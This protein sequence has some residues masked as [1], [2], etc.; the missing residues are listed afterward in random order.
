[1]R[2][3]QV[4][5]CR[6]LAE[7]FSKLPPFY[8]METC[9]G[10]DNRIELHIMR[11][12]P[13]NVEGV[14]WGTVREIESEAGVPYQVAIEW[15]QPAPQHTIVPA[16]PPDLTDEIEFPTDRLR[17]TWGKIGLELERRRRT[18]PLPPWPADRC[19]IC[20][21]PLAATV[22]EGCVLSNCSQRP[23]PDRRADHGF[24]PETG[25]EDITVNGINS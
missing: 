6:A 17:D 15:H 4:L 21:W 7:V 12:D 22:Q 14:H 2:N 23:V 13:V 18:R 10:L 25:I 1:M 24:A 5:A 19:R 8:V 9:Y 20:G 16:P 11:I 3:T